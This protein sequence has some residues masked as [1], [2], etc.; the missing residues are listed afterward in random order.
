MR[1]A[2]LQ[3]R[4]AVER[5][6]EDQMRQRDRGLQRVADNIRQPAAALQPAAG[7]ELGR[8]LR[9]NEDDDAKLLRLGPERM[10]LWIGKLG[11]VNAPADQRAA[12]AETLDRILQLLGGEIGVCQRHRGEADEAVRRLAADLGELLVLQFDDLRGELAL[13]IV[14]EIRID[15][16]RLDVDAL[17]VHHLDAIR[18]DD[19]SREP[20]LLP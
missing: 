11:A 9:M 4:E 6:L 17:L 16:E 18:R 19:Q 10:Q 13:G 7:F 3:P 5:A 12:H 1:A 15:A 2:D 20:N 8:A 14:P